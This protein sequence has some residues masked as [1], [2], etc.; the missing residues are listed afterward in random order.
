MAETHPKISVH[1]VY[2]N[3]KNKICKTKTFLPVGQF[4]CQ[5]G[6]LIRFKKSMITRGFVQFE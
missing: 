4:S 5:I 2:I 3:H 6:I 1:K